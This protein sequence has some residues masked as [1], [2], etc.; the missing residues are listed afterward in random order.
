MNY[1]IETMEK[2]TKNKK[3][4]GFS[5]MEILVA[6]AIIV[7]LSV[8]AFFMFNE[9]QQTRKMA[10]MTNDMD[11]LATGCLAYEALSL[12]SLPPDTLA[13]LATGLTADESVDNSAHD[14][15]VTSTKSDDGT[16]LDPW[17]VEYE[18]DSAERTITCTPKDS[19]GQDMEP[20]ICYF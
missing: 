6:C 12:E 2:F 3:K 17:G 9:G 16:F 8:G 18:Y 20:V 13:D 14:N 7:S 5:L 10:Q 11:A 4:K 15:F 1:S 19:S